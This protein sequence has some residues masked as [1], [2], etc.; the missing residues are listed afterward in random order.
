MTYDSDLE[1]VA[2]I[3]DDGEALNSEDELTVDEEMDDEANETSDEQDVS[4]D[5][6]TVKESDDQTK[7]SDMDTPSIQSECVPTASTS[8]RLSDCKDA[9]ELQQGE[10]KELLEKQEELQ[11]GEQKEPQE[12]PKELEEGKPKE[13]EKK[14]TV[15]EDQKELQQNEL[16]RGEQKDNTVE[17]EV[18]ANE[19]NVT[20][21]LK[22]GTQHLKKKGYTLF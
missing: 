7:P 21:I 16:Q 22:L 17:M 20:Y 15:L 12:K 2:V 4:E 1:G 18:N 3:A 14:Q 6:Q 8:E 10:Q 9:Q 11:Q 19:C 13:L 5:V